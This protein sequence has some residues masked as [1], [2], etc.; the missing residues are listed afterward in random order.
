MK[1]TG[2]PITW[3]HKREQIDLDGKLHLG[4]QRFSSSA[5]GNLALALMQFNT[6][7]FKQTPDYLAGPFW[8]VVTPRLEFTH[9]APTQQ[10]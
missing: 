9:I 6:V 1:H 5:L 7:R 10:K 3:N 2:G 4:I 8:H